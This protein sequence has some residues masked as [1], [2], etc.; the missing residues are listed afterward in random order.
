MHI[1]D[2]TICRAIDVYWTTADLG[3][4]AC[5]ALY[6]W[7]SVEHRLNG[8]WSLANSLGADPETLASVN[9]LVSIAASHYT[10]ALWRAE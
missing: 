9:L 1:D 10:A 2:D 5:D 3:R 8:M 4:D 7:R 6:R